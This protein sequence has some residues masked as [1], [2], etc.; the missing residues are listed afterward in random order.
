MLK[1]KQ[2]L[3]AICSALDMFTLMNK[4]SYYRKRTFSNKH[5][6]T[7]NFDLFIEDSSAIVNSSLY[8]YLD[9]YLTDKPFCEIILTN[10]CIHVYPFSSGVQKKISNSLFEKAVGYDHL[11][12]ENLLIEK[13]S[14]SIIPFLQLTLDSYIEALSKESV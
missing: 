6:I 11:L 13:I 9:R 7:Y 4:G 1:Q 2:A 3:E 12:T 8:P 14:I 5:G 10:K